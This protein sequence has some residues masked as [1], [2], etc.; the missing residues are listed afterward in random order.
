MSTVRRLGAILS[1]ILFV[2]C[3][4]PLQTAPDAPAHVE[5]APP[6]A[7]PTQSAPPPDCAPTGEQPPAGVPLALIARVRDCPDLLLVEVS[8]GGVYAVPLAPLQLD[9]ATLASLPEHV[10]EVRP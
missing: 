4:G 9:A 8:G 10:Q 1:L 7:A 2:A 3:A 5:Q 6:A